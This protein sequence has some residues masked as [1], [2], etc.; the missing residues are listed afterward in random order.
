MPGVT[1]CSVIEVW[2]IQGGDDLHLDWGGASL[3]Y[4]RSSPGLPS[5]QCS[6]PGETSPATRG[7]ALLALPLALP[8]AC[9]LLGRFQTVEGL[10][11]GRQHGTVAIGVRELS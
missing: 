5:E 6:C 2:P 1:G 9:S 3:K 11:P 4:C 7:Q 8:A 10:T